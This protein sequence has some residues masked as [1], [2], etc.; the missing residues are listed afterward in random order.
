MG[1]LPIYLTSNPSSVIQMLAN[2]VI[3]GGKGMTQPTKLF[4][5]ALFSICRDFSVGT[6]ANG[7]D[8]FGLFEQ[9][10]PGPLWA[11]TQGVTM[12]SSEL[13]KVV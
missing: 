7:N 11:G 12:H 13:F 6:F 8:L 9:E 2:F 5:A 4:N 1:E 3:I 10:L